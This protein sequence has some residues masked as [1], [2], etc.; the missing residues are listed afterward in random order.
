MAD[1][2]PEESKL[3]R[4]PWARAREGRFE[5]DEMNGKMERN[6]AKRRNHSMVMVSQASMLRFN[7]G[8]SS[9]RK[10]F[11]DIKEKPASNSHTLEYTL[12]TLQRYALG[13]LIFTFPQTPS[14]SLPMTYTFALE[15][16]L[17]L[18]TCFIWP[19][20]PLIRS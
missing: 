4:A 12:H 1:D 17:T 7:V 16:L 9:Q 11:Y 6:K 13:I 2:A 15:S 18:T 19:S 3:Q 10:V 8:A 5:A 14:S 20:T